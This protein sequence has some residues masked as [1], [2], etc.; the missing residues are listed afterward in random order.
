MTDR[1]DDFLTAIRVD[2]IRVTRLRYE[3]ERC[4]QETTLK[5]IAYDREKV[6]T[7]PEDPMAMLAERREKA[8]D[9]LM[10]AIEQRSKDRAE[11][12]R[13]FACLD[14]IHCEIMTAYY[15]SDTPMEAI[16]G[17]LHYSVSSVYKH[18]K[19]AEDELDKVLEQ[20]GY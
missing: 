14:K 2:D 9:D 12:A 17:T 10:Q 18:R 20:Q 16:A 8:Y 11:V 3:L 19:A 13:A 5:G 4:E 15:L 6:Q 7:S 1:V